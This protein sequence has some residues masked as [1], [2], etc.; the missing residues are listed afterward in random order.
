MK[1]MMTG[2]SG[3][4]GR[5]VVSEAQR[6]GISLVGIDIRAW[7]EDVEM[8]SCLEFHQGTL[9]DGDLM[10][11]LLPGCEGIINS[12]GLHGEDLSRASHDAFIE[13]NVAGVGRLLDQ[14]LKHGVKG[15]ALSSTMEVL[16][17]RTGNAAGLTM[18]DEESPVRCDSAYSTSK[19]LMEELGKC[20][21]RSNEIS[22]ASLRYMAFGYRSEKV[23]GP[24]LLSRLLPAHDAARA[25]ILAATT[26]GLMGEV[27][28]I[29]PQ[30]PIGLRDVPL[31]MQDPAALVERFYPG[32]MRVLEGL[33][34]KLD[35]TD[36]LPATSIRK[37]HERLGWQPTWTFGAWLARAGWTPGNEGT[38]QEDLRVS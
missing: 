15:V 17:G 22:V 20:F 34:F 36:L 25:A 2:V 3:R 18:L 9:D 8:P 32:A 13:A 14:A 37:A 29:G 28:N 11:R 4:L 33:R 6:Q 21:A 26:P 7:P 16:F 35:A 5:A 38:G 12:A 23:G 24:R 27:L 19:Y 1:L 30:T 31:A 10:D